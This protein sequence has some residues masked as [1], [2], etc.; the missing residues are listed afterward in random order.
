MTPEDYARFEKLRADLFDAIA[1][2]LSR[3]GHCKRYEGTFRIGFPSYFQSR[4]IDPEM[5]PSGWVL[6]LDC[7]LIGP[8]RHY[9]WW[10]VTFADALREA[11]RDIRAW[12][13]EALEDE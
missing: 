7:Y 12:M 1:V 8:Q 2:I 4:D 5:P 13:H 9:E 6:M 11:E 10:D 3:D